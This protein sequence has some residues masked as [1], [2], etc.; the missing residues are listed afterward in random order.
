MS[1]KKG[2]SKQKNRTSQYVKRL[3]RIGKVPTRIKEGLRRKPS[4]GQ[5][6]QCKECKRYFKSL[7]ELN[8]HYSVRNDHHKTKHPEKSKS[9]T[10]MVRKIEPDISQNDIESVAVIW[11]ALKNPEKLQEEIRKELRRRVNRQW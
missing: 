2:V 7:S 4:K 8:I 9:F 10:K 5:S 11:L 6:F 3:R 1:R